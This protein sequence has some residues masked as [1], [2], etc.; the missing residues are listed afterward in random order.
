MAIDKVMRRLRRNFGFSHRDTRVRG[1]R[2]NGAFSRT[3]KVKSI[4]RAA[5]LSARSPAR[6]DRNHRSLPS[7]QIHYLVFGAHAIASGPSGLIEGDWGPSDDA[8][9][10]LSSESLLP[11]LSPIFHSFTEYNA[12][13]C[14]PSDSFATDAITKKDPGQDRCR[15]PVQPQ[16]LSNS[17]G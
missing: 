8:G 12:P 7:C 4:S 17:V 13:R 11:F 6:R 3:W 5:T 14:H 2:M 15:R 16:S 9:G 10:P 1:S